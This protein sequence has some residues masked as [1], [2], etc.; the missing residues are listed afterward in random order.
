MSRFRSIAACLALFGL[1]LPGCSRKV[2]IDTPVGLAAGEYDQMFDAAV[3]VLRDNRFEIARQ[4]RR[5]GVI[6]TQPRIAASAFEPWHP[7]R[8]TSR[9]V[10]ENTLNLQRHAV[11]VRIEPRATGLTDPQTG[12]PVPTAAAY[13]MDVQVD[14]ERRQMPPRTLNSAVVSQIESR[15]KA[16]VPRPVRTEEGMVEAFWRPVGRD[17]AYEQQLAATI[18][19]RAVGQQPVRVTLPDEGPAT[20]PVDPPTE[21]DGPY[22]P[23]DPDVVPPAEPEEPGPYRPYPRRSPP[24]GESTDNL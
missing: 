6:T 20:L 14:L 3:E 16:G 21:D 9:Q 18:L 2:G 8:S 12:R 19:A 11:T 17:Q 23:Y 15:D 10:M 5:F 22:Q 1:L 4:D 7:D 13:Q 24:A